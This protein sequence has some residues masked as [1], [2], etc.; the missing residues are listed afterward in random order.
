M[1]SLTEGKRLEFLVLLM[2][3]AEEVEVS[4]VSAECRD[5]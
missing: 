1:D 3:V 2:R 4:E 5:A